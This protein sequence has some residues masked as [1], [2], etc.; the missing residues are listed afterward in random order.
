MGCELPDSALVGLL[1]RPTVSAP[2]S[3]QR[4]NQPTNATLPAQERR[5]SSP[6]GDWAGSTFVKMVGETF[7]R[8]NHGL[9]TAPAVSAS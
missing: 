3:H 2:N 1:E 5:R 9:M 8:A 4:L 7:R 6:R